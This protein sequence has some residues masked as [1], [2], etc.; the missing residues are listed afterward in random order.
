MNIRNLFHGTG[1]LVILIF[2]IALVFFGLIIFSFTQT[3]TQEQIASDPT[4]TANPTQLTTQEGKLPQATP[5][6]FR[7]QDETQKTGTLVVTA[8]VDNVKVLLDA[9]EHPDPEDPIPQG[10][11]WPQNT[12]P[13]SVEE[14]PVGQHFLFAANAPLYDTQVVEFEIKENQI[15]R[16]NIEMVPLRT[17]N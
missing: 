17:S 5:Q 13:F 10:Q 11:I 7:H 15:T 9:T 8:N 2:V 16:V 14:I 6:P 12:T 3:T 1:L 4:P